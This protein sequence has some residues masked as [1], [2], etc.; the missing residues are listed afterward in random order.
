MTTVNVTHF[1]MSGT[2][3]TL[4]AAKLDAT[5]KLESFIDDTRKSPPTIIAID[6]CAA[7]VYRSP[8]SWVTGLITEGANGETTVRTGEVWGASGY[9]SRPIAMQNAVAH[10]LQLAWKIERPPESDGTWATERSSKYLKG[11]EL[12]FTVSDFLR[13]A[14]WQRKYA[15]ARYNGASDEA[16][17]EFAGGLRKSIIR[18]ADETETDIPLRD[19]M[20]NRFGDPDCIV[21]ASHVDRD[22]ATVPEGDLVNTQVTLPDGRLARTAHSSLRFVADRSGGHLEMHTIH[23]FVERPRAS[24]VPA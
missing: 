10:L 13:W 5:V 21:V 15:L 23:I 19:W 12:K 7:L 20:K 16:A 18:Y 14:A 2:G 1:G 4:R 8:D 17:R 22:R 11:S 24:T 9:E 6:C 3:A